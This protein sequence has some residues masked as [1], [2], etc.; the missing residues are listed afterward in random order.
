MSAKKT[1]QRGLTPKQSMFVQQYLKENYNATKAAI[2]SGYSEKAAKE[3]GSRL[4]TNANIKKAIEQAKRE[5]E[6]IVKVDAAW[7]LERHRR[8]DEMDAIDILD[9]DG[10]ILPIRQWP[11]I[12][13]QYLNGFDIQELTGKDKSEQASIIRRIK[14]P[15]KMKNLEMIGKHVDVAA[16]R[17]NLNH[18]GTVEQVHLSAEEH[19]EIRRKMLERDDC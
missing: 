8:I 14:W 12:W 4:L 17:E 13:R 16:Y 2:A 10:N 6:L 7:V 11:K 18:S 9:D 3:Q 15:D 19:A 1:G 5:R